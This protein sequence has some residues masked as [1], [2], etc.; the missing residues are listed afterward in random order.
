MV[1]ASTDLTT[2]DLLVVG[3]LTS[4]YGLKGWLKV[5]SYTDPMENL[6][7]YKSCFVQRQGQWQ[8]IEIEAGRPHGKGLVLKL[9]GVD[10]PEQGAGF[11]G[12]DLA[13]PLSELPKLPANEYYW[14]QLIG[15][16]VIVDHPE[17]GQLTLG[18]VDHLMETGANDV[19]VVCGDE[20]SIDQR[21]RLLPYLPGQVVLEIDLVAQLMRV[22]WDPDF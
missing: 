12:C 16:Q 11:T 13:V 15:L 20:H 21:E 3:R 4:V 5:Y 8:P 14:R 19:L 7:D 6:F 10:N 17:R 2:N 22:D 18:R 1:T 9:R